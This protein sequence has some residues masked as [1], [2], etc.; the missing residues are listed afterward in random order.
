MLI[1]SQFE[2]VKDLRKRTNVTDRL[3]LDARFDEEV[4]DEAVVDRL[5]QRSLVWY[6]MRLQ[7]NTTCSTAV[8]FIGLLRVANAAYVSQIKR[9]LL[10]SSTFVATYPQF[11]TLAVEL[12]ADINRIYIYR[13]ASL[14]Q[15]H[16]KKPPNSKEPTEPS[17]NMMQWVLLHR[18]L[19]VFK[20][21]FASYRT[22]VRTRTDLETPPNF[23]YTMLQ[24]TDGTINARVSQPITR[25]LD[26]F[27]LIK[28]K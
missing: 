20:T 19:R 14:K 27:L 25:K 6:A 21:T 5:I 2:T 3:F 10:G 28:P 16:G 23:R 8:L 11:K 12:G 26:H 4:E 15:S 13:D 22:L 18:A 1:P 9:S 17:G 7:A 24:G